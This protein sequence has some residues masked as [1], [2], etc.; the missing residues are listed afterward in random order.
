MKQARSDHVVLESVYSSIWAV[1]DALLDAVF[2]ELELF[3][4]GNSQQAEFGRHKLYEFK[5]KGLAVSCRLVSIIFKK[6]VASE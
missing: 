5:T 2:S 6:N 1:F 4:F 3:S